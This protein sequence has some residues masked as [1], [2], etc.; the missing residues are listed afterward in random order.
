KEYIIAIPSDGNFSEI[1]MQSKVS[2]SFLRNIWTYKS[3]RLKEGNTFYAGTV[4]QDDEQPYLIIVSA[5]NLV[6]S[7]HINF[8]RNLLLVGFVL[9]ALTTV[10]FS[11]Y[12]SKYVFTPIRQITGRVKQI[13]TDNFHL[14]LD[15]S[16][17]NYEISEL[18]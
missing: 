4:Y 8:L 1:A 3:A 17:S 14:R 7:N 18:T 9:I 2:E 16:D 10:Y 15:D 6:E 13:S 11:K 12:F 5:N